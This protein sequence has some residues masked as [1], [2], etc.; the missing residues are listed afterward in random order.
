[1]VALARAA[2]GDVGQVLVEGVDAQHFE[3][4]ADALHVLEAQV[5]AAGAVELDERAFHAELVGDAGQLFAHADV[6]ELRVRVLGILVHQA[7]NR[8]PLMPGIHRH[9]VRHAGAVGPVVVPVMAGP[10]QVVRLAVI[11]VGL[12]PA[13]DELLV[14]DLEV[15]VPDLPPVADGLGQ[16]GQVVEEVVAPALLEFLRPGSS[17]HG[18]PPAGLIFGSSVKTPGTRLPNCFPISRR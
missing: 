14:Q 6:A 7:I 11:V 5:P 16:A 2:Q 4:V 13:L 9:V 18:K 15:V 8:G 10:F 12:G 3:P 17:L 1:M